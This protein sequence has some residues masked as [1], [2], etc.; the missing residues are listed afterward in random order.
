MTNYIILALCIIVIISY[1]F[2][3][4]GSFSKIPGVILLI[5]LGIGI[6]L[7]VKTVNLEIPNL[8]PVLPVIAV[9]TTCGY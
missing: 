7:V 1:S 2:D 4:S 9:P 5:L 6:Q 8:R 3:I